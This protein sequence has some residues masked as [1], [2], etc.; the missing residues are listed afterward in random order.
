MLKSVSQDQRHESRLCGA[1]ACVHPEP[2]NYCGYGDG[3]QNFTDS[4]F[5]NLAELLP[6]IVIEVDLDSRL[7]YANEQASVLTGFS[8]DELKDNNDVYQMIAPADRDRA[9]LAV[10]R[11]WGGSDQITLEIDVLTR[12][13]S[14]FPT[15]CHAAPIVASGRICGL[16]AVLFDITARR[17]TEDRLRL[18]GR[19]VIQSRDGIVVTDVQGEI[20]YVN[21]AWAR[22]HDMTVRQI[23]GRDIGIFHTEAQIAAEILPIRKAIMAGGSWE[24]EVGHMRGDGI[25][26]PTNMMVTLL[27]DEHDETVGFVWQARDITERKQ[28]ELALCESERRLALLMANLPGMAYRC[29]DND[30]WT[31]LF[32]SDGCRKLT[33]YAPN[34]LV[35]R[36]GMPYAELVHPEDRL[37]NQSAIRDAVERGVPFQ[38]EYRLYTACGDERWVWEQGV[39][40]DTDENGVGALEG[41][42]I[43]ITD[44]VR[45]ESERAQGVDLMRALFAVSPEGHALQEVVCNEAGEPVDLLFLEVNPAFSELT[46]LQ[47]EDVVGRRVTEAIPGIEKIWI[48]KLGRVGVE[49]IATEFEHEVKSLGRYF[50]VSVLPAG[51]GRFATVFTVADRKSED[52]IPVGMSAGPGEPI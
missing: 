40:V 6:A 21:P 28:A 20:E 24:G 36:G 27:R 30:D 15:L 14:S 44:R 9:R 17:F 16:R 22:M 42:I 45:A 46:G 37:K 52:R 11:L 31:M 7:V 29:L 43:D 2:E 49:G 48:D 13:G 25:E 5:R 10:R 39:G 12:A 41:F 4:R 51:N 19:A 50:R 3:C 26:F 1:V 38:I 35:G 18:L 8:R 23:L 33:G 32:V 47:A 34:E